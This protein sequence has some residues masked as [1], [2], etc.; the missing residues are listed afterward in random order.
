MNTIKVLFICMCLYTIVKVIEADT[1]DKANTTQGEA[2][3][4]IPKPTRKHSKPGRSLGR[5]KKKL[6][7]KPTDGAVKVE[8]PKPEQSG[9]ILDLIAG[10][11]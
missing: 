5:D 11:L 2:S 8:K 10:M 3:E 4:K 9:I 1:E 7:T 6:S